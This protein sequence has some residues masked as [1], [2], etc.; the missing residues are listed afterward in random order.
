M[1]VD[2]NVTANRFFLS[3]VADVF[4]V[5][6]DLTHSTLTALQYLLLKQLFLIGVKTL[7]RGLVEEYRGISDRNSIS[8]F[9]P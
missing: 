4:S 6:T 8:L 2:V 3:N 7:K 5:S 1:V 9:F